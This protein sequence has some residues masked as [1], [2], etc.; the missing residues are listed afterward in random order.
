[1]CNVLS[2]MLLLWYEW[3]FNYYMYVLISMYSAVSPVPYWDTAQYN[4][5]IIIIL[6]ITWNKC[7]GYSTAHVSLNKVS[8]GYLEKH[9]LFIR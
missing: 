9:V 1:M 5:W 6:I 8:I 7:Y 4:L 2:F 3:L